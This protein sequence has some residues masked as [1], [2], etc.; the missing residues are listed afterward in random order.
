MAGRTGSDGG[1]RRKV[2]VLKKKKFFI[3]FIFG[4]Q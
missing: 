4:P 1:E 3:F 2:R